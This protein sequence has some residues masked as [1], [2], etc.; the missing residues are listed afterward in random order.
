MNR[1]FFDPPLDELNLVTVSA[2]T[3]A[4][5]QRQV[6]SCELCNPDDAEI[7]FDNVIDVVLGSDPSITDYIFSEPAKCPRC[8]QPVLEKTLIEWERQD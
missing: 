5:A 3:L 2:Y 7:P 8:F 4:K 1:D 6:L